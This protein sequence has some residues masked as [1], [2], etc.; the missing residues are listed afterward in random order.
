MTNHKNLNVNMVDENVVCLRIK[1]VLFDMGNTLIKYDFESPGEVF[2]RILLSL[3][4][5][6]SLDDLQDAFMSAKNEAKNVGLL[7]SFGKMKCEDYWSLW[8]SLV[9]KHLDIKEH[10]ELGKIVQSRWFDFMTC[11]SYPEVREVLLK[12][13]RRGMKVGLVSN[14]YEEEIV[15]VVEKA[16]LQKEIFDLIVGV[17]T[18]KKAKP[19]P[20]IFKYASSKLNVKLEETI[21]IGDSLDLDY[22]GAENAGVYALLIDRSAKKH[23][24]LRA[25]KNLKEILLQ[26][27]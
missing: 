24:D 19:D 17:D 27:N 8:D 1:A 18:A 6:K 13:R 20:D 21:F 3:D 7:S 26:I 15:Y 25:I 10:V 4:I 11:T 12:L 22:R 14:G 16:G 23:D 9:L 2:Q 5:S